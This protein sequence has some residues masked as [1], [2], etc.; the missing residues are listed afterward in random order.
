MKKAAGFTG[1]EE[2]K[3][4]LGERRQKIEAELFPVFFP[5]KEEN[6]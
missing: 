5:S 6:V 3:L 4:G 1:M 2:E